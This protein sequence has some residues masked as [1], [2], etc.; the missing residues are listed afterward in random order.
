MG[1][2]DTLGM[3]IYLIDTIEG[4]IEVQ[5]SKDM[6]KKGKFAPKFQKLDLITGLRVN[7]FNEDRYKN[8][9]V[10][11]GILLGSLTDGMKKKAEGSSHLQNFD[12]MK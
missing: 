2:N 3:S 8:S 5:T 7:I 4:S 1:P 12:S 11:D 9:F 10:V 6:N